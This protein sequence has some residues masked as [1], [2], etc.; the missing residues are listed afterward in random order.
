MQ[1]TASSRPG[2]ANRPL[3]RSDTSL[4]PQRRRMSQDGQ[5]EMTDWL[6]AKAC[7]ARCQPCS[8]ALHHPFAAT[9]LPPNSAQPPPVLPSSP[10]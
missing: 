9:S 3:R 7:K 6:R 10:W 8:Q 1:G 4:L 2:T 5:G